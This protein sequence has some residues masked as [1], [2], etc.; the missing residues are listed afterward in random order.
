MAAVTGS[1]MTE[2]DV[3]TWWAERNNKQAERLLNLFNA[4]KPMSNL[5]SGVPH[6]G[7]GD[8][9]RPQGQ[10]VHVLF[11][12]FVWPEDSET[13]LARDSDTLLD[14]SKLYEDKAMDARQAASRVFDGGSWVGESADAA[15][16]AYNEAAAIKD[17]QAEVSRVAAGLFKRASSDV[18]MTKRYMSKESEDAHKE[19]EAFLRSGSGQSLAEVAAILSVHRTAIQG[20]SSDLQGFAS[21]YTI[22]FTNHFKLG[23]P[24]GP[25]FKQT[26]HDGV[27]Q[28]SD[29]DPT[30]PPAGSGGAPGGAEPGGHGLG[31]GHGASSDGPGGPNSIPGDRGWGPTAPYS[32]EVP[33]PRHNPLTSLMGAGM[34]SLPSMPGGGSGGGLPMGPLQGLMGGFGGLPGGMAPPTGLSAPGLQGS[35][36]PS[37]GMDF[38]RGLA[39]GAAAAGGLPPV[40]QAPLT[41]L[42]APV[43]TAPTSAAPAAAPISA[44]PAAAA[45]TPAPAPAAGVP[46]GG[47]TSYGSVLPPQGMS[48]A[49]PVGSAPAAPSVPAEAS[50]GPSGSGP[51]T[52]LM[53][54]AGRREATAVQ[55]N[56]A[57]SDLDQ[58]KILVAEL[59]GA[60]SVTDPGLDW[61]V[62][63]GR[64]TSGMP[65]YWVATN[66]GAA[67]IP[68]GVF[69]RKTMPVAGGH[70]EE[71]D[72]R[73]FG[74]VNPAD[75]AVR[76]AREFG[77][78]VSAVATSWAMPSDYL[79]EHPVPEVATGVKPKDGPDNAAADLSSSR[80]HRLQTVDA[81]LYS[82]L[83]ASDESVVRDYCR[84]LI[85]QLAFGVAG[86][87]LSSTAQSVAH[88]LVAQRW[89][90]AQEWAALGEEHED[91]LV[92]MSAQ[93]PGL[94]GLEN[95][96]QTISYTR[97][98]VR[99]RQLEALLC[100]ERHGADLLNVVYAA[101][102]AGI[103]APLKVPVRG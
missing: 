4:A 93:R 95:P 63:V 7:G 91:A 97:E 44:A 40:T 38:G 87:D 21:Q 59:A 72:A 99:C 10:F 73:W 2:A 80:A 32:P 67:Y 49:P 43:E 50:G 23:G 84:E 30:A 68:P 47:L 98:F 89:P 15:Q 9:P 76:A 3:P 5:T 100:W 41:S 61:A 64:N 6:L 55:R 70:N 66:D 88:A 103:R 60:A 48:A 13:Q 102:V 24:G 34:P 27:G 75:K 62:A 90:T 46:A 31:L 69:L 83:V 17:H 1:G 28:S 8:R 53:P 19:I 54:V 85:R 11:Q 22:Q 35:P 26:G 65:T 101:W 86:E 92:V 51:G 71:F 45:A 36:M 37:L 12:P 57:E 14:E 29:V 18:E 82:D 52:G 79:A 78:T 42:A 39:A 20:Y 77:D 16:A 94:N 33:H 58:A 96:D 56:V 25:K 81:A 74:W